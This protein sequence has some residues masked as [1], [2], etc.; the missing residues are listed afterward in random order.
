VD[1]AAASLII[2]SA[3]KEAPNYIRRRGNDKD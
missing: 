2:D 1:F 3:V